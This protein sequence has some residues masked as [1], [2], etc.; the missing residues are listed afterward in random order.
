ML[1]RWARRRCRGFKQISEHTRCDAFAE[2]GLAQMSQHGNIRRLEFTG[3][4]PTH[5]EQLSS[6]LLTFL[7]ASVER[8]R[9]TTTASMDREAEAW[10]TPAQQPVMEANPRDTCL[11]TRPA[12]ADGNLKP[13]KCMVAP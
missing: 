9:A 5:P 3:G 2:W 12:A 7:R 6:L 13:R 1:G 11:D 8:L 10:A 4:T